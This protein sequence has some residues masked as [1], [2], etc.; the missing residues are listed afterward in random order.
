M[1][2]HAPERQQDETFAGYKE[3]R[4]TSKAIYK[5]SQR[6]RRS[7]PN[8]PKLFFVTQ[9]HC[10]VERKVRRDQVELMGA[11]QYK[12]LTKRMKREAV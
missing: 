9:H 8:D 12:R 11:R 1:N 2:I 10:S 3:R 4:L 5:E 7:T 6:G